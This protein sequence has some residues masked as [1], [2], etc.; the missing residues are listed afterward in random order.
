[1]TDPQIPVERGLRATV[2]MAAGINIG[3]GPEPESVLT[4]LGRVLRDGPSLPKP[5]TAAT[6]DDREPAPSL[7]E[8][9]A[10]RLPE[11]DPRLLVA[12]LRHG[13]LGA[14][15]G[16]VIVAL[17]FA[18]IAAQAALTPAAQPEIALH[19]E[20]AAVKT[21]R[22]AVG[23]KLASLGV[24]E[25]ADPGHATDLTITTPDAAAATTYAMP[26]LAFASAE[27]R[28]GAGLAA[29]DRVL[30]APPIAA[31]AEPTAA[32]PEAQVA[33]VDP[34]M[35]AEEEDD[36]AVVPLALPMPR[37][38]PA[39]EPAVILP[40]PK[41]RPRVV[42][43]ALTP[44]GSTDESQAVEEAPP[45]RPEPG[46]APSNALGFFSSP[47]EPVRPPSRTTIETPFGVPYVLQTGSVETAC[48]K[49][50]L[51]DIL[52]RIEGH[53]RQKV[54]I[55]SGFRDRGR[56]GSLHRQCAAVDIQ[57]PGVDAASLAAYARTIP[58]IGGV[59]TYCHPH[60]IHVDIGT[61]RDWKY[62]CGS[63]FA[64]RGG[65]PGKWGKVPPTLA[66]AQTTGA[67]TTVASD[68]EE[69]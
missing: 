32:S 47:T 42:L 25:A 67:P 33:A 45:P 44:P 63:F 41:P 56:Q 66:K 65:V 55:T 10:D 14:A 46:R 18:G 20:E 37:A 11:F 36:E 58:A 64:M 17:G 23:M 39:F 31:G 8:R 1:M 29:I 50:E 54:V 27:L 4:R 15:A 2:R 5:A 60:M 61:P 43:A 13:A 19:V 52:R 9:L 57:V 28:E 6:P 68:A 40:M 16:A 26:V 48:I 51:V 22:A 35:I 62:G 38:R 59:G 49:P 30:D 3:E 21:D 53:Y 24:D 7:R 69:E 12:T 34:G